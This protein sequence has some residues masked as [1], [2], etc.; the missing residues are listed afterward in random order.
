MTPREEN[1]AIFKAS[2]Q[3]ALTY[4]IS[5]LFWSSKQPSEAVQ[6]QIIGFILKLEN[7]GNQGLP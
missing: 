3:S 7:L 2:F 6:A 5:F 4:I 1:L